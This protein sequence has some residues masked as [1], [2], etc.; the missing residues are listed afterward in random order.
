[1]SSGTIS[2]WLARGDL[3]KL[4]R[5]VLDGQGERLLNKQSPDVKTQVFLKG[6]P[7][8]LVR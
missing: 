7:N 2:S 3:E 4:E 8:Y 1:M 5:V 6:I